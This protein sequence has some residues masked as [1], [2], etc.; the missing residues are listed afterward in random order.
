[1]PI[2]VSYTHLLASPATFFSA[3]NTKELMQ[4]P[5]EEV[6]ALMDSCV[7]R[8]TQPYTEAVSYTHLSEKS[9]SLF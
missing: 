2:P 7:A 8:F 3:A 1:M 6:L 5:A 9:D 4:A